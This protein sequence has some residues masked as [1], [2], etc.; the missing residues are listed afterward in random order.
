MVKKMK[1]PIVHLHSYGTLLNVLT[2]GKL[3]D[4]VVHVW[5]HMQ[6]FGIKPNLHAYT[7]MVSMYL[8]KE[9]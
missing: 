1:K 6:K 7:I 3:Y 9:S 5:E 4:E 2:K 8:K